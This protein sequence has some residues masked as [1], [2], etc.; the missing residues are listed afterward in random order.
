MRRWSSPAPAA[1][2]PAG[3]VLVA[4]LVAAWSAGPGPA[5]AAE[6]K[7]PAAR[8]AFTASGR[9][10][11][12]DTGKLRGTL[13]EGGKSLGLRPVLAGTSSAPVAG[14]FGL[15]SPYRLLT[16]DARFGSA[17]W[18][19]ASRARLLPDGAVEVR[20]LP[21]KT[22][23]LAIT[24]VYRWAAADTLDCQTTVKPEQD[25]RRFE[26]FLASYFSGFP[27][28]LAY[29]GKSPRADGKPGF[30]AARKADA[31]WHAFPRDDDAVRLIADGRWKRPPNPVDWK[32]R[33]RLA[34]PVALR[35]D[36]KR[37]LTAVLMAPAEDCFAI[38]MPFGEEGHGSV[39]L[40]LFGRDVKAG[41]TASARARLV[42]GE[43]ISDRQAVAL[44]EA[45]AA[46]PARAAAK[47]AA[48]PFFAL[49][50][51]T[52][53]AKRR[54]L[55]QQA[56]M[57]KDLGYDGAG[58]LW[59]G[60]LAERLKTLDAAGLKL[61]QI[62]IRL[63][64]AAG[65]KRPYDLKL[66]DVLPLLKDRG[67]MLAV[68]IGGGKRSD[69]AGDERAVALLREMADLARPHGVRLALYPH[70]G[71]WL[72][73][74]DDAIRV[75]RKVDRPN[76]GAM[77]NLCHFLKVDDEKNIK[78]LLTKAGRL[79]MAVTINGSDRSAD[80]RAGKGKWIVPLDEGNFDM[81]GLLRTLREVGYKGPVGL[82]CYG[83][84]GDARKHLA[85]SIAAWRKLNAR[86]A[87][88]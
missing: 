33:P 44:Y 23:P 53:D 19:W 8:L 7:A 70:V 81:L 43:K 50:M 25:L 16:A 45:Y 62:Y 28:S 47:P 58:H 5:R 15:L 26:L 14:A 35:R 31:Y 22:H 59:L 51:D 71:D 32:V 41:Q 67:V 78:P 74:V 24:A 12:F 10:F 29:V 72:E 1:A 17:G 21:D 40:S 83:I 27:A 49:C 34:A 88:E 86:P 55:P 66:K 36:A 68:L 52:H 61:F 77:F 80:I 48:M 37:G 18:D 79:L 84:G 2:R 69:K 54:S 11:R 65:Q 42:I 4:C 39:Y 87:K 6:K 85:R 9:E 20:W 82:Q 75:A 63:N 30:L 60:G 57:L 64:I 13:R 76:V 46:K 73:R 56:E 3:F 38:S